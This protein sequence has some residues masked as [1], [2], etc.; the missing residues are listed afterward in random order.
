MPDDRKQEK[1]SGQLVSLVSAEQKSKLRESGIEDDIIRYLPWIPRFSWDRFIWEYRR[2]M[3]RGEIH[4]EDSMR[5]AR[6]QVDKE[7]ANLDCVIDNSNQEFLKKHAY[8]ISRAKYEEMIQDLYNKHQEGKL[9][10]ILQRYTVGGVVI[11][12]NQYAR[13]HA[14]VTLFSISKDNDEGVMVV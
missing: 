8:H 1:G 4:R 13:T 3:Y 2:F 14:D 5:L 11:H 9:N 6:E 10:L 7:M 12:L